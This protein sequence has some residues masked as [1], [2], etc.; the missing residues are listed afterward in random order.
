LSAVASQAAFWGLIALLWC[1]G[2]ANP[3]AF[4]V[5]LDILFLVGFF[6]FFSTGSAPTGAVLLVATFGLILAIF[7]VSMLMDLGYSQPLALEAA[8]IGTQHKDTLFHA[9]ISGSL[10]ETGI[11]S[12]GLD[13]ASPLAYHVLAH[14]IAAGL[15]GWIGTSPLNA[16]SLFMPIIGGPL[17]VFHLLWT[18]AVIAPGSRGGLSAAFALLGLL[19]WVLFCTDFIL[20][21][22][23]IS[24]S[25]LVSLWALLGALAI[26]GSTRWHK[27]GYTV[28]LGLSLAV[29][30]LLACLAKISTGAVLACGVAVFF[31]ARAGFGFRGAVAGAIFGLTPFV[32]VMFLAPVDSGHS[33][34]SFIL[35]F[36]TLRTYPDMTLGH[37]ILVT[38]FIAFSL[39]AFRQKAEVAPV[40]LALWTIMLAGVVA[41]L[42]I[43]LEGGSALY[44][45]NPAVWAA[46]CLLPLLQIAPPWVANQT[47][48]RQ[49]GVIIVFI[50]FLMISGSKY[51]IRGFEDYNN[52][53]V[54]ITT[55]QSENS[56]MAALSA[57]PLGPVVLAALGTD[58]VFVSLDATEFWSVTKPCWVASLVVPAVTA[59]PMLMGRP[60]PETGCFPN[61]FYGF[62]DLD[63]DRSTQRPMSN[64]MLCVEAAKRSLQTVT[65]FEPDGMLQILRCDD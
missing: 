48:K 64:D 54:E 41:V 40:V 1:V 57:L 42:L 8:L 29:A 24:E 14:R 63:I 36:V 32:A 22:F 47:P 27:T 13:G 44:F 39:R 28:T 34:Q 35:P 45:A 11:T 18:S 46:I 10:L 56:E 6:T 52:L 43:H 21:S 4:D 61:R 9:A 20:H 5:L 58:G 30:V 49:R 53:L 60:A 3:L 2:I 55:L 17:V 50:A 59:K 25:Y 26:I 31:W 37:V 12:A 65:I 7:H 16:F 19:G 62:G 33:E 23:L 15:S 51:V 38:A